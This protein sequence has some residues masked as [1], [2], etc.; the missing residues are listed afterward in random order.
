MTKPIKPPSKASQLRQAVRTL[1]ALLRTPKTRPGLIAAVTNSA[2]SRNF[3][4]GWLAEG[5]RDG[6]LTVHK[7]AGVLMYQVAEVIINEIPSG[8]AYPSWL[9]PR[10]LPISTGRTVVVDGK[11]IKING[12]STCES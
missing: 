1:K 6:T 3:I 8:S 5:R 7:S 11:T 12:N 2:I 4:F 10:A 9:D